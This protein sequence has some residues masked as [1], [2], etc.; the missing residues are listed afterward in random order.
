MQHHVALDHT[1][2]GGLA[3]S[4]RTHLETE[5]NAFMQRKIRAFMVTSEA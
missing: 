3:D 4:N 5:D 2:M 1:N